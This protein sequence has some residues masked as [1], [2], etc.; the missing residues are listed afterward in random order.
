MR[1]DRHDLHIM[2]SAFALRGNS[3]LKNRETRE[4]RMF[5]TPAQWTLSV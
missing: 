2:S 1:M 4:D 3:A 5:D